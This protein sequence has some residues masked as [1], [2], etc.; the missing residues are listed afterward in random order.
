MK[1]R[2]K[3]YALYK[4]EECL[5]IGTKKELA[6]QFNVKEKTIEF[7]Q[8]PAHLKRMQK[9]HLGNYKVVVCVE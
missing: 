6:K 2:Y 4:G 5:A 7:Y 8:T 9:S 1:N 3:E